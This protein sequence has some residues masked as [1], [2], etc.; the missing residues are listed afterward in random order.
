M[1]R[2]EW[3]AAAAIAPLAAQSPDL[4]RFFQEFLEHWVKA[5]PESATAMRLFTGEEQSR[6]DSQLTDISDEALHARIARARDGLK[7]LDRFDASKFSPAQRISVEMLRWLL[8]DVISE[9][10]FLDYRFP[11]NQFGGTQVRLVSLLTDLHPLRNRQDAE[12][13]LT[14]LRAMGS[15]LDQANAVMQD[16][17]AKGIAQPL[18]LRRWPKLAR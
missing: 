11:L 4:D 5:E 7:R 15:R 1:T 3:L 10:K 16:R 17:A 6:L 8:T 14:R 9:E 2:R 13:Y 18:D 12:N